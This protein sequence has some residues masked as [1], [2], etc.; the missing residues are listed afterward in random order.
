M[1][2]NPGYDDS[3]S[4][5]DDN[6][7]TKVLPKEKKEVRI[8]MTEAQKQKAKEAS[9]QQKAKE[10]EAAEDDDNPQCGWF[11]WRPRFAQFFNGPKGY[12]FF[13]CMFVLAQGITVNGFVFVSITTLERRFNLP[14]VKSGWIA[15]TY[16]FS[17][18]CV[19]VFV[20][21]FGEKGHKPK[22]LALGAFIFSLGSLTFSLPHFL[23]DLYNYE[24]SEFDTCD[25]SR[26]A[27][28]NCSGDE[29]DLSRYYGFFIAGQ[30]LHGLG[31]APLYTLGIT[32]MDENVSPHLTA[33]FLGIFQAIGTLGPALGFLIGG[34]FLDIYTDFASTDTDSLPI[35]SDS[36]L[37]VGAWWMGF[38]VSCGLGLLVVF[39]LS[40]FTKRLPGALAVQEERI[41]EA[42][43]GADFEPR[44]GLGVNS[45]K[46]FPRAAW[47]LFK[48][49]TY[50]F[51]DLA[52]VCEWFILAFISV[53]GPKYL[54]SMFNLSAGNAAL[55]AGLIVTPAGVIGNLLGGYL[56]KRLNLTVSGML[57]FIICSL[58]ISLLMMV[59]FLLACDNV[60]FAGVTV[61][62]ENT[63]TNYPQEE[64][65]NLNATCNIDCKCDNIFDPVCG[66][67]DIMYYSSCYA[68]CT[69][70]NITEDGTKVRL[71]HHVNE[72][73][74][75]LTGFG[76]CKCISEDINDPSQKLGTALLGRCQDSCVNFVPFL[77]ILFFVLVLGFFA[78]V[79]SITT[80]LRCIDYDQRSFGMGFQSLFARGLGSVPGPIAVGAAIDR[81]CR[82]WEYGCNGAQTCWMYRNRQ[83]S[84]Y[85]FA[86]A[87]CFR[88][89]AVLCYSGALYS[90]KPAIDDEKDLVRE[91]ENTKM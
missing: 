90:Y 19:I 80:T 15:S 42:R 76:N 58:S 1:A 67:N 66:S 45:L 56:V 27:T 70:E 79:P 6:D 12:L 38:L 25:A 71:L 22:F 87:A 65:F 64:E 20:T 53:F 73:I 78:V 34:F 23:T 47:N 35:Q 74:Q 10:A 14:S 9:A 16:D 41:E 82:V 62:Y 26:N 4:E 81:T 5:N 50:M 85:M 86:F 84:I 28:D 52:I 69:F 51:I 8:E 91:E 77:V 31:A 11:S 61:K 43:A 37:W 72:L 21:Y 32:Y 83:L 24:G 29:E 7:N 44:A 48:N 55:V 18:M 13:V 75:L 39:P 57:K 68:G 30:V 59:T 17:V 36:P 88:L 63:T 33:V 54:E 49:P 60:D 89:G 2:T 40:G 46:D 3:A